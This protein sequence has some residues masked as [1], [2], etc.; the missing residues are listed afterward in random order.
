M[1][2]REFLMLAHN[3][4][5]KKHGVAGWYMSEKLDGMRAF[6]DGGVS[7]EMLKADVPWANTTKDSRY[8][9]APVATG[10]WSQYGHPIH[11][12]DWWLDALPN[13][14]LDGELY[15]GLEFRQDLMSIVKKLI[16]NDKDWH[17]IH[18]HC[19][20]IPYPE[21]VFADG[22]IK[23]TNFKKIIDYVQC[24]T[25]FDSVNLPINSNAG[26]SFR[27]V[28][29]I[30][31][32]LLADYDAAVCHP[33]WELPFSTVEA[34]QMIKEKLSL[35]TKAGG[36]GLMLRSPG[37][38][39]KPERS[40][41]LVKVKKLDDAE[42]VV[43]GYT[44][45]R[46]TD[47]GSKLLGLMGALILELP[48]GKRLELSGFNDIERILESL[49]AA[50]HGYTSAVD[51]AVQHPEQECPEWIFAIDFPRDSTVTF[52]YRGLTK[53]GIPQ[54]ARY[55]RKRDGE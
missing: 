4:D 6:W 7:R 50:V 9:I 34:E 31:Q 23:T 51:W 15:M 21:A 17:P 40:H 32:T 37:S 41:Q 5:P 33:Q 10:L 52:R 45:G 35:I 16:P 38:V 49:D 13:T 43:V 48:N 26:M 55:W 29:N 20:D 25:V 22:E 2:K 54:E 53:D 28:K 47:L 42:G 44:T 36:E 3:Y 8:K 1:A 30:L 11:A 18:L 39:W 24:R 19:F 14:P 27:A 46:E 12:P